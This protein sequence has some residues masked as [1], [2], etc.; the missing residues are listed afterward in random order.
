MTDRELL[1]FLLDV[2]DNH[3]ED[4]RAENLIEKS[5]QLLRKR[6]AQPEHVAKMNEML[7]VQGRDGTWN[8]SP[9]LRG[10]YNG[11]EFMLSI[12]E[13][14]EPV[15]RDEPE[16]YLAEPQ[17]K[18]WVGLP[19][20]E[21]YTTQEDQSLFIDDMFDLMGYTKVIEAKLKE[22]NT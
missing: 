7:E 15:Y 11:M 21:I 1:Q 10:M 14:R 6:L 17:K 13:N 3:V 5:C 4:P 9:Y 12:V 8:Y 2:L 18:E 19:D 20:E 16:K 22:K